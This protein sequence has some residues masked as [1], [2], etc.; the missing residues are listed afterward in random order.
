MLRIFGLL[1]FAFSM[2]AFPVLAQEEEGTEAPGFQERMPGEPMT[3]DRLETIIR[4][5]DTEATRT[6]NGIVFKYQVANLGEVNINVV[7]DPAA[8]RMRVVIG[9][10]REEDISA[11]RMKRLMQANFDSALDA[12]YAI[13]QEILWATFLH[14][15]SSLTDKDFVSGV[16]QTIGIVGTYGTTYSSGLFIFGGGDSQGIIDDLLE[17]LRKKTEPEV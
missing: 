12:R 4:I 7:T 3:V 17:E 10:A 16:G 14:P 2:L 15:L 8:D 11:D 6:G 5:F 1:L 9:I 13:G